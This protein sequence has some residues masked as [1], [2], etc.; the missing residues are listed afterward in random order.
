M[1]LV[2][3]R[4]RAPPTTDRGVPC[5]YFTR[6]SHSDPAQ[7]SIYCCITIPKFKGSKQHPFCYI[8]RFCGQKFG[9]NITGQF[10]CS[11]WCWLRSLEVFSWQTSWSGRVQESFTLHVCLHIGDATQGSQRQYS[12]KQGGET[13]HFSRPG[14]QNC[15]NTTFQYSIGQSSPMAYPEPRGRDTGSPLNEKNV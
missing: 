12:R 9:L 3:F 2:K 13:A 5:A 4:S 6:T 1:H 10:F 14:S 11:T 8:S 7:L 15:M